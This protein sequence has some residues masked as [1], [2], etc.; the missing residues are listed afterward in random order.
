MFIRTCRRGV[1]SNSS[2]DRTRAV[3]WFNNLKVSS[4]LIG[5]FLVVAGIGA[6][7]GFNGI[8]K[9]AQINDLASLMYEREIAGM[10]HASE[11]NLQLILAGRG[12]RSAILSTTLSERQ[13][14]L[15]GVD[16]RLAKAR[17]E[18]ASAENYFAT[19]AGRKLAKEASDALQAY[20][21]GLQG[22]ASLLATEGLADSRASTTKLMSEVRGLAE[23]TDHLLGQLVERKREDARTLNDTTDQI[24]ADIRLLLISL[25]V[26]GVLVGVVIGVLLTRSLTRA[27][28]G[29]PGDVARA[30]ATIAA[31]DLT[32]TMDVSHARPGSVVAAMA[33]MQRSLRE[34]VG[35]VRQASDSIATG[36]GQI[37]AGNAD[38]SQRTEEQA[39]NLEETAASME[40]LTSTVLSSADASRQAAELAREASAS[41]QAGGEVVEKVVTTMG[42]INASSRRISD[43][44]G[45]IDGIAFQ[46]N[47]LALN[48]AVEAARAG[49]QGRGFAVV[50]GEVRNLA[51]KSASAAKE[52][53]DL[54][55]DSLGRS[56]TA[57][58][59][60]T[61]RAWPWKTSSRR[62]AAWP[63]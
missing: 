17:D 38:L 23:K 3:E 53:K 40:E 13:D 7:I 62:C 35:T 56:T 27:L 43:I 45:V 16:N 33:D 61:T 42:E 18:L 5:G 6:L 29:E 63:I 9:S 24:Y 37:A 26:G 50:A 55:Q 58:A 22:V 48:A 15:R 25:T 19:E 30:A 1:L 14:H 21:L 31:G 47:I 54:I 44:I 12:M 8:Q 57:A 52:I 59:W 39:S 11:A 4:K 10:V 28:G 51:Q 49:E 20:S 32:M 46:T 34:V 2:K 60:S 36:A 41:A